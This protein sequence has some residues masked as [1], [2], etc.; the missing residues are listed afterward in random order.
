MC[1]CVC[2]WTAPPYTWSCGFL[3]R[4]VWSGGSP[5]PP[6]AAS[7]SS[8]TAAP[9]SLCRFCR[10]CNNTADSDM[11][12]ATHVSSLAGSLSSA[13]RP[14]HW[15][16]LSVTAVCTKVGKATYVFALAFRC[17]FLSSFSFVSCSSSFSAGDY[18]RLISFCSSSE[19]QTKQ[20][21]CFYLPPQ[22]LSASCKRKQIFGVSLK[23]TN[24]E[25]AGGH[26]L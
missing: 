3:L 12:A 16:V 6:A 2:V 24:E 25:A 23:V 13:E 7:T 15:D 26:L 18:Q 8:R 4:R 10:S 11:S 1:V 21:K 17:R 14:T 5:R 20:N 22:S 19:Q 9:S